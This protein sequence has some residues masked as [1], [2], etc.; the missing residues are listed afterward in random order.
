MLRASSKGQAL[1]C[2]QRCV[3]EIS[4]KQHPSYLIYSL[5]FKCLASE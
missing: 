4:D 1:F 5:V 2:G 3:W